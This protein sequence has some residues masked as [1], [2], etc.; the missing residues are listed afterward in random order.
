MICASI[1]YRTQ[2]LESEIGDGCAM[3]KWRAHEEG[4]GNC[5]RTNYLRESGCVETGP[6]GEKVSPRHARVRALLTIV[7]AIL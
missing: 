7:S 4:I 1:T 3:R 6:G 5:G 2:T